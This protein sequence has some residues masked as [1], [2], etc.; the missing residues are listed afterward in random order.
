MEMQEIVRTEHQ[1]YIDKNGKEVI[2][3]YYS[4]SAPELLNETKIYVEGKESI[5]FIEKH[6]KDY[7]TSNPEEYQLKFAEL[8]KELNNNEISFLCNGPL[9][10]YRDIQNDNLG[11]FIDTYQLF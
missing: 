7:L 10:E 11:S 5:D 6:Y 2:Y 4:I 3:A 8:L 9:T 1:E